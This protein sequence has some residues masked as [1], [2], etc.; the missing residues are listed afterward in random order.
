MSCAC[1]LALSG[2]AKEQLLSLGLQYSGLAARL[3][4]GGGKKQ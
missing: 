1:V 4:H 2:K 3:F